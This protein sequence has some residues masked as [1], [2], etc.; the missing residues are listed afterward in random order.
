MLAHWSNADH[1]KSFHLS[2]GALSTVL[3]VRAIGT[4]PGL[5]TFGAAAPCQ[6]KQHRGVLLFDGSCDNGEDLSS[7]CAFFFSGTCS[8]RPQKSTEC[9]FNSIVYYKSVQDSRVAFEVR[10]VQ[11]LSRP[12]IA[13]FSSHCRNREAGNLDLDRSCQYLIRS[14]AA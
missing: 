12:T 13:S 4:L 14:I 10:K 8:S 11:G 2:A 1:F 6:G 3:E 5:A 7:V 9:P